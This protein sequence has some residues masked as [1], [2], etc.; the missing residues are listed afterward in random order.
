MNNIVEQ[1]LSNYDIKNT[2]DEINSLKE[3]IQEIV[4]SELSRSN[5]FNEATFYRGTALR[6]FYKLDCFSEDL[7]FALI[8]PNKNFDLSKYFNYIEKFKLKE[9]DKNEYEIAKEEGIS[10]HAIHNE[11]GS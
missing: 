2:T 8:K 3:I 10:H 4:L 7:A 6:I 1:M 11:V 5:F 9:Q